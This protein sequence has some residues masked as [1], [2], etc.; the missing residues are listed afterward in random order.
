MHDENYVQRMGL[1][2]VMPE[3]VQNAKGK[4]KERVTVP[5]LQT[6]ADTETEKKEM[7]IGN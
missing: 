2:V 4:A 7:R 5:M 3:F 6:E 1:M